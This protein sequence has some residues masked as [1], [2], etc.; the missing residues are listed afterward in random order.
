ME[1]DKNSGGRATSQWVG[2]LLGPALAVTMLLVGPPDGLS[3][4]GWRTAAMGV[5]MAVWWA[6]EAIP[7]AAT[8]L[9]PIVFFAM[10]RASSAR[11]RTCSQVTVSG[12][13][14]TNGKQAKPIEQ[15]RVAVW[16]LPRSKRC[17]PTLWRS[18]SAR[19]SAESRLA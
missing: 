2:L 16:P 15:E 18:L 8:A 19:F 5:L 14:R 10:Y 9:L 12:C 4:E 11:V 13:D 17:S 6:T 3:A 1:N 7:I